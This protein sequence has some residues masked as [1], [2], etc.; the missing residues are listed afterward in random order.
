MII[1]NVGLVINLSGNDNLIGHK[2]TH[3]ASREATRREILGKNIKKFPFLSRNWKMSKPLKSI[4][5][6]MNSNY[7]KNLVFYL[8]F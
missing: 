8:E 6:S 5:A 3:R 1:M 4:E 2:L 7:C